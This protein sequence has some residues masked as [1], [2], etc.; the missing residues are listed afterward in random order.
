MTWFSI[1]QLYSVSKVFM[2]E[3]KL[4]VPPVLWNTATGLLVTLSVNAYFGYEKINVLTSITMWSMSM[5]YHAQF[6]II[7]VC[8][9]C[10][11]NYISLQKFLGYC[12][13]GIVV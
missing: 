8:C 7:I 13:T 2:T 3:S 12:E 1:K 4:K 6:V 10:N 11:K 5:P 9:V